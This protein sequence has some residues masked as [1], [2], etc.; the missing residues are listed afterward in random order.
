VD[1]LIILENDLY[2]RADAP[3]VDA[4][5]NTARHLIVIDHLVNGVTS[6]AEVVLP[7]ATFAEG[8]GS[9]VNNE[10]RAQRFYQ[11]FAHEGEVRES[12]RWLRDM[13]VAAGRSEAATWGALD[14][15]DAALAGATPVFEPVLKIA[16]P[17][18]F[19]IAGQKIP[20]Q[21][22]RYSGRTAMFANIAVHEPKPPDDPDSPLSFSMEGYQGQPPS[23]LITRYWSPGWNSVQALN[24]FQSEVGGPLRGGDPGRRLIEPAQVE[25]PSYFDAAPE[26]F[27]PRSDEWL[28]APLYHAFGSEE[29]SVL[30]AGIAERAPQ[31][32][33]ALNPDDAIAIQAPEGEEAEVV[34]NGAVYRLPVRFHPALPRGVAG[35][36]VGLSELPWADLPGW[37]IVSRGKD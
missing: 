11:V 7:A 13:M 36:P 3:P 34:L 17:A 27:R 20:R 23:P 26:A 16:P 15:I 10:G 30:S 35:L 4:L 24:K 18:G 32:Y 12:W 19:R 2:R 33:L 28:V 8:D 14:E 1:T 6:K 25:K 21:P 22:H 31:P 9:L 5:L 29:L 37:G